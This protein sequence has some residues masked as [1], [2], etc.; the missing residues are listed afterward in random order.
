MS[1]LQGAHIFHI[2]PYYDERAKGVFAD[3]DIQICGVLNMFVRVK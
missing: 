2:S 3:F 1:Q